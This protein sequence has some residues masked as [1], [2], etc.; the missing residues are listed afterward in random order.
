[1]KL[2]GTRLVCGSGMYSSLWTDPTFFLEQYLSCAY[3]PKFSSFVFIYWENVLFLNWI[4][5]WE[6]VDLGS[7]ILFQHVQRSSN[8]CERN[9]PTHI[10]KQDPIVDLWNRGNFVKSQVEWHTLKFIINNR[11][12]CVSFSAK[13]LAKWTK[14][15]P[16]N[17]EIESTGMTR[18]TL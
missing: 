5:K 7:I 13:H 15:T 11:P 17:T 2:L 6:K 3:R 10:E 1:M 9:C 12:L 8:L 14:I 18:S 4:I 16:L